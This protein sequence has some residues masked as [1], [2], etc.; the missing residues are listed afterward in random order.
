MVTTYVTFGQVHVHHINGKTFYKDCVATIQA[1]NAEEAF[2]MKFC[3]TYAVMQFDKSSVK[4][5][6]RGFIQFES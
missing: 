3:F 2:G 1:H 6:P 4:Y 5:F